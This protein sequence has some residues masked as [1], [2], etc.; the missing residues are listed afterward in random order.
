MKKNNEFVLREMADKYILLPFGQN[1]LDFNGVI[2]LNET[3]KFIWEMLDSESDIDVIAKEM[4]VKYGIDEETAK[5]D[6]VA[7]IE[8]LKE[9]GCIYD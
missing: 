2:T 5:N 9:D 6:T 3:G 8:S 1:A 4:A 7:F